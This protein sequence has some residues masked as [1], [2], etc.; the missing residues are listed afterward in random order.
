MKNKKIRTTYT[1]IL[2]IALLFTSCKT[3]PNETYVIP[4]QGDTFQQAL[5]Q[6]RHHL[7]S[8]EREM[9]FFSRKPG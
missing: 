2:L 9:Q 1:S 8:I 4:R 3:T 5:P 6:Q 7:L